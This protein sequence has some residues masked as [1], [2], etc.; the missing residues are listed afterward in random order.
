M[1][2][3]PSL[4]NDDN[5]VDFAGANHD[6]NFFKF[7]LKITKNVKTIVPLKFSEKS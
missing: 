7:K 4:N 5:I 1:E 3:E 6:S 2:D